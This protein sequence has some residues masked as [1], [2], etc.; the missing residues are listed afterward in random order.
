MI[1]QTENKAHSIQNQLIYLDLFLKYHRYYYSTVHNERQQFQIRSSINR[2]AH[3]H[4]PNVF[5]KK[6]RKI[7]I[8][9]Y[10]KVGIAIKNHK[11]R[12][13]AAKQSKLNLLK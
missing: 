4:I 9:N 7:N 12:H 13:S 11:I 10:S 3:N 8:K 6:K 2:R 5:A 1:K